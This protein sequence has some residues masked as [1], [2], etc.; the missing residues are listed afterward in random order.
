VD[1]ER[2][3]RWRDS[4]GWNKWESPSSRL[5]IPAL[6]WERE[7]SDTG[8]RGKRILRDRLPKC[9]P[10]KVDTQDYDAR[11]G[12]DRYSIV[13]P[14]KPNSNKWQA[15]EPPLIA[16]DH[17]SDTDRGSASRNRKAGGMSRRAHRFSSGCTQT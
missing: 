9:E 13:R 15:N 11:A 2:S 3:Y 5:R 1:A 12:V 10:D 16:R 6:F 4:P 7:T 17:D 14:E 8:R